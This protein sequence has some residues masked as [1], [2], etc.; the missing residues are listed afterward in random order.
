MNAK[1]ESGEALKRIYSEHAIV[2]RNN[3]RLRRWWNLITVHRLQP[4]LVA[5]TA[6]GREMGERPSTSFA[7]CTL[8]FLH[9]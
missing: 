6:G 7:L 8:E 4:L 9:C 1:E 5:E 2:G 3:I